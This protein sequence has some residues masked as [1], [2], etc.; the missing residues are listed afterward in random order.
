[1]IKL[2]VIGNL[3]NDAV[4]NNVNGKTV[5][6][7][8]LAHT[9]KYKDA[10]GVQMD[11]T[12]WVNCAYWTERTG[13]HPYLLKGK[14]I[15]VEGTPTL[16]IYTTNDGRQSPKLK[17]NVRDIQLI[18]GSGPRTDQPQ[19]SVPSPQQQQNIENQGGHQE[20]MAQ[21]GPMSHQEPMAQP[22]SASSS[23]AQGMNDDLPF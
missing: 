10:Q 21:Q 14:T 12:I 20:P 23:P 3:G 19:V 2:Q 11:R 4:V 15:Y 6:N 9:E 17:L 8:S 1:M 5:I 22:F 18:G 7:F 13:I 16:E